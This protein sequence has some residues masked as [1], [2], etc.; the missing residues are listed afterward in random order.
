MRNSVIFGTLLGDGCL[1]RDRTSYGLNIGHKVQQLEYLLWKARNIGHTHEPRKRVSGYG[2]DMRFITHYDKP[3]LEWVAGIC[4]KDGVKTVSKEWLD[5]LDDIS[6]AVWYQDDGHWGKDG[7]RAKNGDRQCRASAFSTEGFD[8]HSIHMLADWLTGCGYDAKVAL[9][10]KKYEIIRLNHSS[11][12]RLWTT[13]APYIVLQHK[14]DVSIKPGIGYCECGAIIEPK[15][16]ICHKCVWEKAVFGEK[17]PFKKSVG[18][19]HRSQ[20]VTRFGTS[21]IDTLKKMTVVN[22][23]VQKYWIDIDKIGSCL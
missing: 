21:R 23:V 14:L 4:L 11:T 13:V 1:F 16:K 3:L 20:L 15:M 5:Q 17:I 12:I 2:T 6:L 22:P 19:C 10:K 9:S 18:G 7:P 8:S